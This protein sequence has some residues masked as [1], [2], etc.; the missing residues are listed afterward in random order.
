MLLMDLKK[1][2]TI[3][4]NRSK[5]MSNCVFDPDVVC[6]RCGSCGIID[7][8]QGGGIDYDEL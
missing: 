4:S 5:I 3:I 2:R 1:I 6:I 8:C 7:E